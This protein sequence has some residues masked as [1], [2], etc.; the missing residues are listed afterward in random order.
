MSPAIK[1][2]VRA[3]PLWACTTWMSRARISRAIRHA[4]RTSQA[5]R[6]GISTW[7]IPAARSRAAQWGFG[8]VAT[9]TAWPRPA[10]PIARSRSWIAAPVK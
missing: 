7:P 5:R 6:I 2:S 1:A 10:S 9:V 3:R 4:A 8:D